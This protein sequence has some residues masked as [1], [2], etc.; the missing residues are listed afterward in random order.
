M[1]L[2]PAKPVSSD[3]WQVL[4]QQAVPTLMPR[5]QCQHLG[6]HT[7][8]V[9]VGE[10]GLGPPV[11]VAEATAGV[12]LQ[13]LL[14]VVV[15]S[16]PQAAQRLPAEQLPQK[17][18]PHRTAA[19][20]IC[21]GATTTALGILELDQHQEVGVLVA[22]GAGTKTGPRAGR[23]IGPKSRSSGAT[24]MTTTSRSGMAILAR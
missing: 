2:P 7:L 10:T 18:M 15:S 1:Q 21:G 8:T 24:R 16:P 4:R 6:P 22:A 20:T 13:K 14:E 11:P 9:V 19:P 5:T 23:K 17:N 12:H 3:P